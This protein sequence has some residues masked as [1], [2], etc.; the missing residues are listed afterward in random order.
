MFVFIIAPGWASHCPATPVSEWRPEVLPPPYFLYNQIVEKDY[1][2]FNLSIVTRE[3][4][5]GKAL[6][7]RLEELKSWGF[8]VYNLKCGKTNA[9]WI[10]EYGEVVKSI[11]KVDKSDNDQFQLL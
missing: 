6:I 11:D 8:T 3:T 1:F 5:F 9:E 10:I 7:I 2:Q 4:H